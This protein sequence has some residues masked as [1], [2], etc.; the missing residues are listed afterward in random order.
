MD[1]ATLVMLILAV[2]QVVLEFVAI[3]QR[4]YLV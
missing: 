3:G 2:A 4:V 1:T